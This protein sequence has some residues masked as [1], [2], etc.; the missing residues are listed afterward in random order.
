MMRF[1]NLEDTWRWSVSAHTPLVQEA[2]TSLQALQ[3]LQG[4]W[5]WLWARCPGATAAQ[6]PERL[7]PW[8]RRSAPADATP[9]TLT[10]RS[11]G[12][13][14]GVAPLLV[15]EERGRRVVRLLGEG[16]TAHLDVLMDPELAPHG[17]ALLFQWLARHQGHWEEC[18]LDQVHEGSALL[19]TPP[20]CAWGERLESWEQPHEGAPPL[21]Q[22]R[23]SLWMTS[24]TPH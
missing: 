9:W 18:V 21:L 15:Q 22:R 8:Y 12:R 16:L 7:L 6:R 3:A 2:V 14:V 1:D 11:E 13:L 10:L 19:R 5:R 4:E 17:V 24:A 20:P 23:R